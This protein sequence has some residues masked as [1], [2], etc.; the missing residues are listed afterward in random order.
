V[1]SRGVPP[2]HDGN[3]LPSVV[4][5]AVAF[6]ESIT[7]SPFEG[8]LV[9]VPEGGGDVP[10]HVFD[11]RGSF[12]FQVQDRQQERDAKDEQR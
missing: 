9:D 11:P 7:Q 1:G 3:L 10:Y 12:P 2:E 6:R 4:A 5:L 8:V